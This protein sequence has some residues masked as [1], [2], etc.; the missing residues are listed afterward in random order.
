MLCAGAAQWRARRRDCLQARV[1]LPTRSS[2]SPA[3][4]PVTTRSRTSGCVLPNLHSPLLRK[5]AVQAEANSFSLALTGFK[6]DLER[7]GRTC[8]TLEAEVKEL[9]WEPQASTRGLTGVQCGRGEGCNVTTKSRGRSRLWP[10]GL[11]K[12]EAA[13]YGQVDSCWTADKEAG[14]GQPTGLQE[15]FLEILLSQTHTHHIVV[16][17]SCHIALL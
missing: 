11:Q 10:K 6:Q 17:S 3:T 9:R 7:E 12:N 8:K 5:V 1:S 16:L 14:N 4:Q 2:S 13:G 15:N